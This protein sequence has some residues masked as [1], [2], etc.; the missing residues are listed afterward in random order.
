MGV[1]TKVSVTKKGYCVSHLSQGPLTGPPGDYQRVDGVVDGVGPDNRALLAGSRG[2][3]PRSGISFQRIL[4]NF[5]R[6]PYKTQ[7]TISSIMPFI[8]SDS[9]IAL[10]SKLR[11]IDWAVV[12]AVSIYLIAVARMW[13]AIR[14][15]TGHSSGQCSPIH[16]MSQYVSYDPNQLM[17]H[18]SRILLETDATVKSVERVG[19]GNRAQDLSIEPF[20]RSLHRPP[21]ARGRGIRGS[22]GRRLSAGSGGEG[23]GIRFHG[24]RA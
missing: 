17:E 13:W 22:D 3:R 21:A 24:V 18:A 2:M 15:R 12:V 1:S 10:R 5:T 6:F 4:N 7:S 11:A 16:Q 14:N 19:P 8:E 9:K 20:S 23:S